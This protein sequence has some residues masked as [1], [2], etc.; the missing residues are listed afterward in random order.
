MPP[1]GSA[2]PD[3][4]ENAIRRK[5]Y[6]PH[7]PIQRAERCAAQNEVSVFSASEAFPERVSLKTKAGLKTKADAEA[8]VRSVQ[9]KIRESFGPF[10]EKTPLE[11]RVT[12]VVERDVYKIEKIIFSSRPDFLV[13][14]NLYIPKGRELP[15]P[16][17]AGT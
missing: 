9:E 10:P 8:Y 5:T 17:V 16:G 1:V 13:T 3:R 7:Q 12:G 6:N 14:A 2:G 15:L 4:P 11:P